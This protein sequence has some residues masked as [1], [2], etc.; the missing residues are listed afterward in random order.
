M[1]NISWEGE[2]PAEPKLAFAGSPG[3]S[4]SPRRHLQCARHLTHRSKAH[5]AKMHIEDDAEPTEGK[6]K[7]QL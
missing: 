3:G 2:A 7:V 5:F 1:G 4:P 6:L